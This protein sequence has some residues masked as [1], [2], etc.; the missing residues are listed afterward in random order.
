MPE[1]K[2]PHWDLSNVYPGLDSKEFRADFDRL[3]SNLDK[4][5]DY[6][7]K[8]GIGKLDSPPEDAAATGKVL[9]GALELLNETLLMRST[10]NAYVY[11]FV[12]TDSRNTAAARKQSELDQLRVRFQKV[13]VPFEAWV[14]SLAP[15]LDEIVKDAP[16]ARE[17]KLSLIDIAD[18]SRFRMPIEMEALASELTVSG[19]GV[20][21]KL[22]ERVTSQLKMPFTGKDGKTEQLPMTVIRNM[23]NDSDPDTRKRAY[24]V[25]IR[26]W[27]S[28]R[29]PVAFALNCV[30]GTAVT[31]ARRRGYE[32]VLHWSLELNKMDRETLDALLGSMRDSFPTFRRY[33][34]SKAEKLGK[35]KLAWWDMMAPVGKVELKYTWDELVSFVTEQFGT[36]S[37]ELADFAGNAFEHNWIDAEPRDG[38]VGGGFCMRVPKVNESRILSNFDGS[39]DQ[40]STVSHE[41]GH[42]FHNYCQIGLPMIRAGS[43]MTLAE[44]ASIFCETLVTNA[45]LDA[46]EPDAQLG[47]LENQ[48]INGSQV[49]VDIYSR[50]LFESE[51]VKRRAEAELSADEFCEIMRDAQKQTYGDGVHEATYHQY[52]W[53]LKP[54]YYMHDY[55]FYNYP[56]A[57]GLLFGLGV[58]AIYKKEGDSF[59]P[60]Y[61][62]LLR[63]TGAGKAADLAAEYGIDIRSRDFWDGSIQVLAKQVE[64]YEELSA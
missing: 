51:V 25:E 23:A 54:H 48:L 42:A 8:H 12:A 16:V 7:K 21:D 13:F 4:L 17:H 31:L 50:F 56:Y 15:K 58:Y 34:K 46:A 14:G 6:E 47:I 59:I 27:D 29:E 36:F 32:D 18:E 40:L 62:E 24:E 9:D 2:I 45:A 20:M 63:S 49:I 52:M 11:S 33:F 30:K 28:I 1:N 53:L 57:F 10:L 60:R 5:E 35:E 3:K 64:R 44:T 26:G 55:N 41:L 39:F 19:G 37:G 61:K 43:P 38:K 22:Q